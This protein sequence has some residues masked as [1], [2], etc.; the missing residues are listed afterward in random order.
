[1]LSSTSDLFHGS[2]NQ[3]CLASHL[4][5]RRVDPLSLDKGMGSRRLMGDIASAYG[6]VGRVVRLVYFHICKPVAS[7]QITPSAK[8]MLNLTQNFKE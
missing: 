6:H 4:S 7:I 5:P 8:M 1:M 2:K 3:T